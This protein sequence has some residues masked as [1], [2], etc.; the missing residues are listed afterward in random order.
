MRGFTHRHAVRA[1]DALQARGDIR[2]LADG[3]GLDASAGTDLADDHR[4]GMNTH[5]YREVHADLRCP[6]D[7]HR[8]HRPHDFEARITRAA[9]V[10]FVRVGHTEV[11]EHAVAQVLH[12]GAVES[13]HDLRAV[14]LVFANQ[15]P[16]V[17]GIEALG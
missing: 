16:Q 12:D 7:A 2:R 13:L 5:A 8:P 6:A 14:G 15:I 10:V 17:F 4:A 1:G 3:E 11:D 9:G